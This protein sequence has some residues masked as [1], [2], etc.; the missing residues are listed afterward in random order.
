MT[1][2]LLFVPVFVGVVFFLKSIFEFV[3]S[4]VIAIVGLKAVRNIRNEI[5]SHLNYLSL[6]F[7]SKGR[8]G[9]LMSRTIS[10]VNHIQGAITD[11]L[12]DMVKSPA[13][14]LFNIPMIFILGGKLGLI[15]VLVLPLVILPIAM[16][17]RKVRKFTRRSQESAADIT[18]VFH[19]AITGVV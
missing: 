7:F 12:V 10:D 14:I 4:Y 1:L 6:D 9:D 18:S 8:T 19:E 2:P 11:V 13:V 3:S 15:A 17:G 16:L 5:Y